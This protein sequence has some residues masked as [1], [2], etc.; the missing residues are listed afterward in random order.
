MFIF[1]IT[2]IYCQ[3]ILDGL[4]MVEKSLKYTYDNSIIYKNCKPIFGLPCQIQQYQNTQQEL[5]MK[6]YI[7]EEA[8]LFLS[9]IESD[10]KYHQYYQGTIN[11]IKKEIGLYE[12][13]EEYLSILMDFDQFI[14]EKEQ[15]LI[16]HKYYVELQE[17]EI[18]SINKTNDTF[19]DHNG[20]LFINFKDLYIPKKAKQNTKT[21]TNNINIQTAEKDGTISFSKGVYLSQFYVKSLKKNS[22]ITLE[23][24]G[25]KTTD[26]DIQVDENWVFIKGPV[27]H[28][29]I[30]ITISKYTAIDSILIKLKKLYYTQEQISMLLIQN[31]LLK[32]KLLHQDKK[33]NKQMIEENYEKENKKQKVIILQDLDYDQ[34]DDIIAFLELI[35]LEIK[36][37]KGKSQNKK[38]NSDQ[39]LDVIDQIIKG[40]DNQ[41][42]LE[43]F[44]NILEI[45][46]QS[47]LNEEGI[48]LLYQD[49]IKAKSDL[50]EK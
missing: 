38:L 37:I 41:K 42:Q 29:I 28:Q 44:Q 8:N 48:K 40:Q 39:I 25:G 27:D 30:N 6:K 15:K 32:Q 23:F 12:I 35:E 3:S 46:F 18:H 47:N 20:S 36:K 11:Q 17:R 24:L 33:L 7:D 19:K 5:K 31:L 21:T 43:K 14:L 45:F 2:T 10:Q 16:E 22:K 34:I 49:L 13:N 9:L 4:K 26:I 1:I 50:Q